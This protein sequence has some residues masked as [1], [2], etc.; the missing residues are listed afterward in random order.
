[1]EVTPGTEREA[2]SDSKVSMRA[3]DGASESETGGKETEYMEGGREE[4]KA[5][6]VGDC[7]EERVMKVAE[8]PWREMSR[9]ASS[10]KGVRCPMPGEGSMA[11]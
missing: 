3:S 1:M 10:A 8:K 9:F 4:R 7:E 11:I 6:C 5:V 2:S